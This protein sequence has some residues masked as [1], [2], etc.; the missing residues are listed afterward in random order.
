[1][2]SLLFVVFCFSTGSPFP[3]QEHEVVLFSALLMLSFVT[4]FLEHFFTTPTD[5][6]A[7]TIAILLLL[8]PLHS[9]LNRLGNWYWLF[10]GYN[11]VLL[12]IALAA[13]LL[14]D[15]QKSSLAL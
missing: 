3:T 8:A 1:M 2:A 12:S 5:V 10:F 13:L 9:Q 14:V 6:L 4:L 7:S 15:E 11:L